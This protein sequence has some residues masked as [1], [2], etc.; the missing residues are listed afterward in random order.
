MFNEWVAVML[1]V[2]FVLAF[3]EVYLFVDVLYLEVRHLPLTYL[4][5]L[6][7]EWFDCVLKSLNGGEDALEISLC[8]AV[9]LCF[10]WQTLL[11]L[12]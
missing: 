3:G 5:Y 10:C 2:T 6:L 9:L 1:S 8:I 11:F 7:Q 4:R 12:L